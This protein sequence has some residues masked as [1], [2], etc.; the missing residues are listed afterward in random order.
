MN[1]N[2]I[3]KIMRSSWLT[4]KIVDFFVSVYAKFGLKVKKKTGTKI[5]RYC[6]GKKNSF[7]A[8][9]NCLIDNLFVKIIGNNN[10]I[11]I[12]NNV[13]IH[14]NCNFYIFGNNSKIVIGDNCSMTH[15]CQIEVQEEN[16]YIILGK[17]CMLSNHILIRNNDS[18]FIY[19]IGTDNRTNPPK[20]VEIGEHVWLAAGVTVL[21]GVHIGSGSVIGMNSIVTH[22]IS[23]NC[24]AAG[25]PAKVV[26]ENVE[27]SATKK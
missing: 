23:E 14:K 17:D 15:D 22:D 16:Q 24:I 9:N 10:S 8:G 19:D 25:I 27:W 4:Y 13:S 1:K 3:K 7:T 2:K 6:L 21:K 20:S 18:H 12:G 26:K 11:I 5:K